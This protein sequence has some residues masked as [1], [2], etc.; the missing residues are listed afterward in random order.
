MTFAP[1]SELKAQA[2]RLR[3]RLHE[4]G[5]E[6]THGQALDLLARQHGL[7]DWNSL[8]AK[9]GNA[10]RLRVGARVSG[11]YLGQTFSGRVKAL[12]VME[13]GRHR[14]T[15]HFDAPVDVVRFDSFSSFRQRVQAV[16]GPDGQSPRKT[17]DGQP[18]LIVRPE[19]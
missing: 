16:I 17:S 2:K 7:R 3:A 11:R 15:V 14:I 4:T 12:S 6:I 8:S 9:A 13:H 5:Q 19:G 18:Q 10:P 1:I